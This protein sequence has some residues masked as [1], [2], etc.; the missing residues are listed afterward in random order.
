MVGLC[1]EA[2]QEPRDDRMRAVKRIWRDDCRIRYEANGTYICYFK[3]WQTGEPFKLENKYIYPK[4]RKKKNPWNKQ[5]GVFCFTGREDIV[6]ASEALLGYCW[7]VNR[8]P[9]GKY[10]I[11]CHALACELASALSS[12]LYHPCVSCS[13]LQDSF[14]SAPNWETIRRVIS[15]WRDS[16][17]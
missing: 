17:P 1:D 10:S 16:Y 9:R 7:S 12:T 2:D 14:R 15:P 11:C 3:A 8:I 13:M 4:W 6:N 5:Q